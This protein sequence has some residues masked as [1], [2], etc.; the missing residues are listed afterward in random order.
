MTRSSEAGADMSMEWTPEDDDLASEF[1]M[2]PIV[3]ADDEH[4]E[5]DYYAW[6]AKLTQ[7]A[8][9]TDKKPG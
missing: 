1:I 2:A 7:S 3:G 8:K 9:R 5:S 6:K 4:E